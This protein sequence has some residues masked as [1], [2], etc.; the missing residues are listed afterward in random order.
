MTTALVLGVLGASLLG[1]VH[2]AA[3]CGSFVCG[4]A[5]PKD[6]GARPLLL[7]AAYN[8]GRLVSY[9]VLGVLAGTLGAAVDRSGA[10]AGVSRGA[11]EV[12][13]VLLMAWGTSLVLQYAGLWRRGASRAAGW[14]QRV[15]GPVLRHT[16]QASPAT[17]A[18][19]IG[20]L[21]ALLPCGWLYAFVVTAGGT[22]GAASAV[23]VMLAFWL[24]T[25]PAMLS[26]GVVLQ[27]VSGRLRAR[28]PLVTAAAVIL[29]GALSIVGRVV[30]MHFSTP[31]A[32]VMHDG[33]R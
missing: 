26:M 33:H 1:S 31:G 18:G 32:S 29:M 23:V 19:T 24:G 6:S 12:A 8:G 28:L 27:R 11:T 2:C 22:G 30:P 25:L 3:M 17:R 16:R 9:L 20:L 4:Y 15:L 14:S 21:S 10:L 7:H 5:M 13:G